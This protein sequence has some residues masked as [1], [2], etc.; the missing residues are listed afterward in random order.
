M[1]RIFAH[2]EEESDTGGRSGL[3]HIASFGPEAQEDGY[4]HHG[5]SEP[6]RAPHH[7]FPPAGAIQ[8]E[9]WEERA[10]GEH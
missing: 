8:C 6:E 1:R 7:G 3:R 5:E 10:D 2:S 4:H 9:G